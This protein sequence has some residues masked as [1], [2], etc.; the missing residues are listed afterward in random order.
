MN[1]N[2][3]ERMIEV[4]Q[5][6]VDGKAIERRTVVPRSDDAKWKLMDALG[7]SWDWVCNDYRVKNPR[8]IYVN[9]FKVLRVTR[10]YD[11]KK[12]AIEEAKRRKVPEEFSRV[13]VKYREV[14]E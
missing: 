12:E 11:S 8:V 9:E 3:T 14:I 2:D 7:M 4:M 5:A 10:G 13:A 1:K 6:Y